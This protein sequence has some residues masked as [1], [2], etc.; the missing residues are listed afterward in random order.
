MQVRADVIDIIYELVNP[1][2]CHNDILITR[3]RINFVE[4]KFIDEHAKIVYPP[5]IKLK[6]GYLLEIWSNNH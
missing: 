3:S 4:G 2:R 1:S 5:M 6:I